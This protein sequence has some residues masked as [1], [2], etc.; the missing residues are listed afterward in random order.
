MVSISKTLGKFIYWV[1]QY[2]VCWKNLWK[3]LGAFLLFPYYQNKIEWMPL[4]RG[5]THLFIL[6]SNILFS[7][8]CSSLI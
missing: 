3:F 7:S 1:F 6:G 5:Y 8:R 4:T 2:K